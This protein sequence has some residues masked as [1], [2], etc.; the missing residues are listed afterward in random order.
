MASTPSSNIASDR[1]L[2]ISI[3]EISKI[4][5]RTAQKTLETSTLQEITYS[6]TIQAIPKVAMRPDLT[7]FVQ[8]EGDYSGLVI[9]NFSADAAFAIY[10]SYMT[11]MGMPE[12][13][14]GTSITSPEVTD[15]IGEISNQLMGQLIKDV[16]EK[17]ELNASFGQPKALTLNSAITLVIDAHYAENRRLSMKIGN[18]SFRIEIAMEHTE[19]IHI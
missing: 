6:S 10:K 12:D 17:F 3:D 16:E 19:F 1:P 4:F 15:S 13:E 14:L 8:F 7:C 5:L 2:I 9:L 18:Y 11:A